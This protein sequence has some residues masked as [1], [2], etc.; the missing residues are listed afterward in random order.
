MARNVTIKEARKPADIA[1]HISL[2]Y[3]PLAI[4]N[5]KKN[6]FATTQVASFYTY[7]LISIN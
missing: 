1:Q 2:I 7:D 4:A 6:N 5:K 3:G